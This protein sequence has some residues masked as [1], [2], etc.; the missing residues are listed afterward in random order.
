MSFNRFYIL[1][2]LVSNLSAVNLFASSKTEVSVNPLSTGKILFTNKPARSF[3]IEGLLPPKEL[4]FGPQSLQRL[5][6]PKMVG[7]DLL[8]DDF[9]TSPPADNPTYEDKSAHRG[10]Q[11][12]RSR[13][14][15]SFSNQGNSSFD[16]AL[17]VP[18]EFQ[19]SLFDNPEYS[20]MLYAI[21]SLNQ[22]V[23]SP[24]CSK[25]AIDKEAILANT[26][27]IQDMISSLKDQVKN[28]KENPGV[29]TPDSA[30]ENGQRIDSAIL[31]AVD[32]AKTFSQQSL[33]QET[34]KPA[35]GSEI[36][37]ALNDLINGLTPYALMAVTSTGVGAAAV[38][39]LFGGSAIVSAISSLNQSFTEKSLKLD[40]PNLRKAIL[41]N[42]CQYIKLTQRNQFLLYDRG[43]Q[44][45]KISEEINQSV[46]FFNSATSSLPEDLHKKFK[47]YEKRESEIAFLEKE[48]SQLLS[49]FSTIKSNLQ[50]LGDPD[51][52]CSL[53]RQFIDG[54]A[55]LN[56]STPYAIINLL[57]RTMQLRSLNMRSP[58]FA[59]LDVHQRASNELKT[60][61][62]KG[63]RFS[64]QNIQSCS[65][66]TRTWIHAIENGLGI[67]TKITGEE[68][69]NLGKETQQDPD[70]ATYR[71]M[72]KK[73]VEKKQMADKVVLAMDKLKEYSS[74]FIRSDM[75]DELAKLRRG[76]LT[77]TQGSFMGKTLPLIPGSKSPVLQW[78]DYKF[79]KYQQKIVEFNKGLVTLRKLAGNT[80]NDNKLKYYKLE[81]R[82][83]A[84]LNL[85]PLSLK[86]LKPDS[87]E[88]KTVC[89]EL[90]TTW[91]NYVSAVDHLASSELFCAMLEPVIYDQNSVDQSIIQICQGPTK[92]YSNQRFPSKILWHKNNLVKNKTKDWALF[93]WKY[94][95]DLKCPASAIN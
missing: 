35:S 19:C 12:P 72:E 18:E 20:S 1:A 54:E 59:I 65:Q 86:N 8:I 63:T 37:L 36:T 58:A 84:I 22:A 4:G 28:A 75:N 78:F 89:R 82:K 26:K 3:V 46:A 79:E 56:S 77:G 48:S 39:Y 42:T 94:I 29:L 50:N 6:T 27:K 41:E 10:W 91:F 25:E 49:T 67:I 70:Y 31:A 21:Q 34:C 5:Y 62:R 85:W 53:A 66:I 43:F 16:L 93:V 76:L 30:V 14:G 40:D 57:Q 71:S 81:D 92:N 32:L 61:F 15:S 51:S 88:H 95:N 87:Q 64:P 17:N 69:L 13:I 45:K 80:S 33:F 7:G 68:K 55:Q 73:L 83:K 60:L 52:V 2:L 74:V 11:A 44:V 23:Q 24:S 90:R 47:S 38:P 9:E